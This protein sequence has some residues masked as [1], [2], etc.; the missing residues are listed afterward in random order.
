MVRH[1]LE[2]IDSS[3]LRLFA[4]RLMRMIWM[5]WMSMSWI[6]SV[7]WQ[8]RVAGRCRASRFPSAWVCMKMATCRRMGRSMG[9]GIE[10]SVGN[11]SNVS[12]KVPVHVAQ[13]SCEV[14]TEPHLL[15]T[16]KPIHLPSGLVI[17]QH[18]CTLHTHTHTH[19]FSPKNLERGSSVLSSISCCTEWGLLHN[20]CSWLPF[21]SRD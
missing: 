10:T 20:K 14:F 5:I 7:E 18:L 16:Y 6:K 11:P 9:V 3:A 13:G 8:T 15:H 21:D 1:G 4:Y 19:T 17:S 2:N 12:L